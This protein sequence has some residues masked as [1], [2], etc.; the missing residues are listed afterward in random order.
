MEGMPSLE[1]LQAQLER[2]QA[3]KSAVR[4]AERNVVE[5]VLKIQEL[6]LLPE[7]LLHT[8]TGREFL[9]RE[10]LEEEVARGVARRG[11]R[12]AL[13]DLPPALG[14]D[15]VHCERAARAYVAA[16]RGAV[17]EIQGELLSQQYFDEVAVE[18]RELLQQQGRVGLGELAL[19]YNISAE[20]AGREVGK[21]VG[22]GR[23]IPS[24]RLE[25]ELRTAFGRPAA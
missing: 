10:R 16:S 12:L 21:R 17:E 22:P 25:G 18:V 2:A 8:V 20:M 14:V 24:G 15:L 4:L 6:G 7:P 5:L 11:G 19:R 3:Q 23:A 1:E 9:T 13:V